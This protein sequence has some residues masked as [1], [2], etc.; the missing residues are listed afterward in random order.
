MQIERSIRHLYVSYTYRLRKIAIV[1][2]A[3]TVTRVVYSYTVVTIQLRVARL[4]GPLGERLSL[5]SIIYRM[6]DEYSVVN[7]VACIAGDRLAL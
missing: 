5:K 7:F 1:G 4:T 6:N 2:L 3:D